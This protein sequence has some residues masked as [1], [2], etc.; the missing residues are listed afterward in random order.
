MLENISSSHSQQLEEVW[1]K[2]PSHPYRFFCSHINT[3]LCEIVY[4]DQ[5]SHMTDWFSLLHW[6]QHWVGTASEMW[7]D[8]L[9][10]EQPLC[11]NSWN[12]SRISSGALTWLNRLIPEQSLT[13]VREEQ[14][15]EIAISAC[16]CVR[17]LAAHSCASNCLW[18]QDHLPLLSFLWELALLHGSW[19]WGIVLVCLS[20]K[21]F[22][23]EVLHSSSLFF[24][25]ERIEKGQGTWR[26][27]AASRSNVTLLFRL[28]S[29]SVFSRDMQQQQQ[30]NTHC[31][32]GN[33]SCR[34]LT[35]MFW[36]LHLHFHGQLLICSARHLGTQS[37]VGSWG[38]TKD[39]RRKLWVASFSEKEE[40]INYPFHIGLY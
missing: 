28:F 4:Q 25:S 35:V 24:Q 27:A 2:L 6:A 18:S 16:V 9:S 15:L 10:A 22:A 12:S 29:F 19:E 38:K 40:A 32:S 34:I 5:S 1:S 8:E 14:E 13:N 23:T 31:R 17:F 37:S 3:F 21:R 20:G 33:T 7:G 39:T 11:H 26:Y 36:S 30:Q